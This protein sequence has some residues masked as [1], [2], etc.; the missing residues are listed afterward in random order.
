[1]VYPLLK[2]VQGNVSLQPNDNVDSNIGEVFEVG[3]I[4]VSTKQW[5]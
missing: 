4:G 1:M 3:M 2:R 5:S